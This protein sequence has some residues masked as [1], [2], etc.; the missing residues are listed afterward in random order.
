MGEQR[1]ERATQTEPWSEVLDATEYG[2]HCVHLVA[3]A[4]PLMGMPSN[5]S[6]D[7]LTLNVF[8]PGGYKLDTCMSQHL[9]ISYD[10]YCASIKYTINHLNSVEYMTFNATVLH[11][12]VRIA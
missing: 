9:L 12:Q 10:K 5:M 8:V 4:Y 6:E 1:F 7:C 3:L 2:P 11:P